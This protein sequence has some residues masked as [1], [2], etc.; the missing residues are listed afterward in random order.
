MPPFSAWTILPHI[1]DRH[2]LIVFSFVA[3]GWSERRFPGGLHSDKLT[4]FFLQD[5]FP[6][7]LVSPQ[8]A[9]VNPWFFLGQSPFHGVPFAPT[10]TMCFPVVVLFL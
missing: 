7:R 2:S 8:A 6:S 1:L 4:L 10:C 3:S 9:Q 5:I